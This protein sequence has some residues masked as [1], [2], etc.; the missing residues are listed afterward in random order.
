MGSVYRSNSTILRKCQ[1]RLMTPRRDRL[2]LPG[3]AQARMLANQISLRHLGIYLVVL[4][5]SLP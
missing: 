3:D 4:D 5:S 1:I 2:I